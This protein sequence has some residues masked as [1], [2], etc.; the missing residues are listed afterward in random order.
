MVPHVVAGVNLAVWPVHYLLR[1]CGGFFI[2]R[3]FSGERIHAAVFSPLRSRTAAARLHHGVLH[4]RRPHPHRQA[5]PA[6]SRRARHGAR[7]RRSRPGWAQ[8]HVAAPCPSTTSRWPKRAHTARSKVAQR[9]ARSRWASSSARALCCD[10]ATARSTSALASPSTP[11]RSSP[12]TGPASN[13]RPG[14]KGSRKPANDSSRASAMPRWCSPHP[15]R[16]PPCCP[17]TARESPTT[18]LIARATRLHAA[19]VDEGALTSDAL[20]HFE[21]A[22]AQALGA[23]PPRRTH[24]TGRGRPAPRMADRARSADHPRLPQEPDRS[25]LR[26]PGHPRRGLARARRIGGPSAAL[27]CRPIAGRRARS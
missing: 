1:A 6:A 14:R 20:E 17:T 8:D 13:P 4:R 18:N 11:T 7:H 15:S 5:A 9:S 27:G 24:P 2:R 16:R 26:H 21:P 23:V 19:L 12:T 25:L 22:I 10:A 3:S